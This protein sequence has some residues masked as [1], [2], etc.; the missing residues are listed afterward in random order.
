MASSAAYAG[1]D[2][3]CDVALA[4]VGA[5]DVAEDTD[6]VLAYHHT[7]CPIARSMPW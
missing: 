3:H 5:L 2:F 4:D 7:P 1:D 6:Q